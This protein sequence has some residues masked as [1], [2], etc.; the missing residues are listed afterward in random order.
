M[1]SKRAAK[2]KYS[3]KVCKSYLDIGESGCKKAF[4]RLYNNM[5]S[6]LKAM[7]E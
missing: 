6:S 1:A 4:D 7:G 5:K 2:K 3:K